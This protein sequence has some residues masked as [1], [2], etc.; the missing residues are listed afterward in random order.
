MQNNNY[1]VES[2]LDI[3]SSNIWGLDAKDVLE[4]WK[5]DMKEEDFEGS[6]EKALN[7]LRLAF[8]VSHFDD[9]N[10][11]EAARY[12]GGDY[13]IL[14]HWN[15]KK[16]AIAIRKREIKRITDLSYE[17]VKHIS[18]MTLLELIDR[19]FGG[20]W[21][22]I[23]LA[24]KDIIESAFDISTTTLPATRIHAK[25]GTL[26]RKIADGYEVLEIQ[27]GTWIEA[28]FAKKKDLQ[29]KLRFVPEPEY[30][31]DGNRRI[32]EDD[33]DEDDDADEMGDDA[34]DDANDDTFYGSYTPEADVKDDE[35]LDE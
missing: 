23:S 14:P 26:E 2:I 3:N 18:A 12:T 22:S 31:E 6:E 9:E 13:V 27:K 21:D 20:G 29:E 28:I 5:N 4:L 11:R 35:L 10:E 25:G 7:V 34:N 17:N 8:E 15:N 1:G 33:N 24:I 16:G 32:I 30:D 19:N